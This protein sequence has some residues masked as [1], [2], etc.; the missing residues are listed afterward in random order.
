MSIGIE[1]FSRL[2]G[3]KLFYKIIFM[4]SKEEQIQLEK[5]Y[6]EAIW[7]LMMEFYKKGL[8]QE[9]SVMILYNYADD[10]YEE[11]WRM[12]DWLSVN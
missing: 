2:T 7:N 1:H 10:I 3:L 12:R 8:S 4:E 11:Y 6:K 5:E 9:D